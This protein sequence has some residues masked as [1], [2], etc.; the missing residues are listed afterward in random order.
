MQPIASNPP[1][2][3]VYRCE[4]GGI[5]LI[6]QNINI[7]LH[8][9]EF[10]TLNR[11]V[12]QA[13]NLI[14]A[15]IWSCSYLSLNWHTTVLCLS[16]SILPPLAEVMQEAAEAIE[17]EGIRVTPKN[18]VS[19][20]QS[21]CKGFSCVPPAPAGAQHG[22]PSQLKGDNMTTTA[23]AVRGDFKQLWNTFRRD[24]P[25]VRIRDAAE[26]L[27][28]SEAELVATSCGE[29][30][31]R[32][33]AEWPQFIQRLESLGPVMALTR[34]AHAVHEKHGVFRNVHIHGQMGLVLDE[35]IDLRLFLNHWRLGFAVEQEG[36]KT[37]LR[38]FQFFN[39]HGTAV[40]KVYL[41][42]DSDQTAY[43][44]LIDECASDDQSPVQCVCP[45]IPAVPDKA[46]DAID[47]AGLEAA[48]NALED[49]HD[50]HR[51]LAEFQVGRVQALRLVN[52]SLACRVD[53]SSLNEV[54][55][56]AAQDQIAIMV[57]VASPGVI[58]IHSGPDP[59]R[60]IDRPLA[61]H[62]R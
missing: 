25:K 24:N 46:D 21:K 18:G 6:C 4:H 41:T 33:Q 59:H 8:P 62:P 52:D 36:R 48:W 38:G 26:Q 40:H 3:S 20:A 51:L 37:T 7:G 47:V 55:H 27:G 53:S 19:S 9:D 49:T 44:Q 17:L 31:I 56:I 14:E 61:Q 5:H 29:D 23:P 10:F 50:F 22:R 11:E 58:Q 1:I 57:F 12:Q 42:A 54:L 13:M 34:N 32:L 28:V 30:A 39:Q 45:T 2:A 15:G 16:A 43:Q 35:G 60:Q